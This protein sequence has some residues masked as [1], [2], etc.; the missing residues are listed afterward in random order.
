MTLTNSTFRATN[1]EK[2]KFEFIQQHNVIKSCD[3]KHKY[4]I[5]NCTTEVHKRNRKLR[6]IIHNKFF[7][8]SCPI[9]YDNQNRF[10][11]HHTEGLFK[12]NINQFHIGQFHICY[13]MELRNTYFNFTDP[14]NSNKKKLFKTKIIR[15][16]AVPD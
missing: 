13:Q 9:W 7:L 8:Y 12:I 2:K 6:N 11:K 5:L 15:M 1:K 16:Y 14:I 10:S 4:R 3:R